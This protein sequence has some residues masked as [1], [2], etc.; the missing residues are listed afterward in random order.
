MGARVGGSDAGCPPTINK[1]ASPCAKGR[2]RGGVAPNLVP[3]PDGRELEGGRMLARRPPRAHHQLGHRALD[4]GAPLGRVLYGAVA[5]L[6]HAVARPA[7]GEEE[8]AGRDALRH[9]E[10]ED[11]PLLAAALECG[12]ERGKLGQRGEVFAVP[13]GKDRRQ[14]LARGKGRKLEHRHRLLAEQDHREELA[15]GRAVASLEELPELR[16]DEAALQRADE[17]IDPRDEPPAA[18]D[19][20]L[21][22]AAARVDDEDGVIRADRQARHF[23]E[24]VSSRVAG[25]RRL[26]RRLLGRVVLREHGEGVEL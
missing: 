10:A 26:Q 7:V 6:L 3:E 15:F 20:G 25:R 22:H 23:L 19:V 5:G 16:Q 1:K 4:P 24:P 14:V 21:A 13:L 9:V 11:A 18:R 17:R 2:A 12:D 8:D